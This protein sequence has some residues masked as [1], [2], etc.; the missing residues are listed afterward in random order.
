[1]SR[2]VFDWPLIVIIS[3]NYFNDVCPGCCLCLRVLEDDLLPTVVERGEDVELWC[4][5]ELEGDTLYS[6]KWYRN[7]MEF[8][9]Y[10]PQGW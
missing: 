1:M 5:Y 10:T 8:Y 4:R 2:V 3:C 9:R 7:N 6:L